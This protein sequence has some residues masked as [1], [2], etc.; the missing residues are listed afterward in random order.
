[1]P[2]ARRMITFTEGKARFNDRVVGCVLHDGRRVR[3]RPLC[4]NRAR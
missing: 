2:V 1:M 3:I 4:Y